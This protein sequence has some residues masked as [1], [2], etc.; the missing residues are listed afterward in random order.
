MIYQQKNIVKKIEFIHFSLFFAKS[1]KS[2]W[3][4]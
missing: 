4:R 1:R 3:G 2:W